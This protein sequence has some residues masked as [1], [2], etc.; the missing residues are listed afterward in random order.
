MEKRFAPEAIDALVRHHWPGNLRELHN[1][2]DRGV[3]MSADPPA[4]TSACAPRRA[5][6]RLPAAWC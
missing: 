3:V 1:A 6:D 5:P 4:I 2:V